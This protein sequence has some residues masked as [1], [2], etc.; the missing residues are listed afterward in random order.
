[1]ASVYG[2]PSTDSTEMHSCASGSSVGT[3]TPQESSTSTISE[4]DSEEQLL[5]PRPTP[6]RHTWYQEIAKQELCSTTDLD[7]FEKLLA[8]FP[9]DLDTC[10]TAL[11][12]LPSARVRTLLDQAEVRFFKKIL[13]SDGNQG[14][15]EVASTLQLAMVSSRPKDPYI[16]EILNKTGYDRGFGIATMLR[17]ELPTV[18]ELSQIWPVDWDP[19]L[20]CHLR[21]GP[22]LLDEIDR[23]IRRATAL[24]PLRDWIG[25]AFNLRP[26]SVNSLLD[27]LQKLP[28]GLLFYTAQ[29][30]QSEEIS[31]V[32]FCI[33]LA[34]S[35]RAKDRHRTPTAGTFSSAGSFLKSLST[36][37]IRR[38]PF[39]L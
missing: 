29:F 25:Y 3:V 2:E 37:N 27:V 13:D 5:L 39:M 11:S 33:C 35:E 19:F 14:N 18:G 20:S 24:I 28:G 26:N 22:E 23:T 16:D 6:V 31:K 34:L 21:P 12:E 8:V 32:R 38:L 10:M 30:G 1:M 9:Y 4:T 7:Y 36:E 15:S 17:L